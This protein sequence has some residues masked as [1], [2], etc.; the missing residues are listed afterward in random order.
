M[1]CVAA[2]CSALLLLSSPVF[3]DYSAQIVS[4]LDADTIEV[5]HHHHA[6]RIRLYGIDCPEIGQAYGARA[7]QVTAALLV[8]QKVKIKTHGRDKHRR[9][10]GTAV[11]EGINI[12]HF[13]VK[14]GWCWWDRK[15]APTHSV[16]EGLERQ[17]RDEKLGLWKES[18][19]IP[20]WVYRMASSENTAR[21]DVKSGKADLVPLP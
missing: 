4:I 16:L 7:K 3:A 11:R 17:A 6:E 19:P 1:K 13:L 14:Q 10:L 5:V 15:A 20:P 8:G 18:A 12:N 2:A 9:T 21:S